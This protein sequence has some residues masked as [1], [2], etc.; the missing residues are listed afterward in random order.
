MVIEHL[1]KTELQGKLTCICVYFPGVLLW[2]LT[3]HACRPVVVNN[4]FEA[5]LV[6]SSFW[7]LGNCANHAKD[8][9]F[10]YTWEVFRL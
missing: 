7:T 8:L 2:F 5:D 4:V 3:L 10:I 1:R 6:G 9:L